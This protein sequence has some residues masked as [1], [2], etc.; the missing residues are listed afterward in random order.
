[1]PRIR[2][3]LDVEGQPRQEHITGR[4]AEASFVIGSHIMRLHANPDGS[5]FLMHLR[6]GE[7]YALVSWEAAA[8]LAGPPTSAPIAPPK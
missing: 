6:D 3:T 5:G 2:A 1:M 7:Q 4:W 8:M